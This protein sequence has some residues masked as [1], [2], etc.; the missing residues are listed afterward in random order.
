[1]KIYCYILLFCL[2]LVPVLIS[3]MDDTPPDHNNNSN[4]N[5]G[6]I[7]TQILPSSP[8]TVDQVKF[9][10]YG[11][12]YYILVSVTERG[13]DITVKKRFNS[14]MKLPCML[15]HDT[16]PLGMLRQGNYT[17]T[18]LIVDTNPAVS[19][20]ISFTQTLDLVVGK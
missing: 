12:Q 3:C 18:F 20:S 10:T 13:K 6:K 7:E 19:D 2:A 17:L 1:M 15:V 11:C 16:I 14:Q 4:N 5:I 8:T 9:I